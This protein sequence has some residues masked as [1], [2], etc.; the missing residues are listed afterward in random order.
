MQRAEKSAASANEAVGAQ[1]TLVGSL[2]DTVDTLS[3]SVASIA[4][5]L[6]AD[7]CD[8]PLCATR[9]DSA[10][11]LR[12]RISTTAQRLA[13]ALLAQEEALRI[14]MAARDVSGVELGRLRVEQTQIKSRRATLVGEQ[15]RRASLL[16]RLGLLPEE[17]TTLFQRRARLAQDAAAQI[18]RRRRK[19]RWEAH[20]VLGGEA[21]SAE[22][23]RAVRARDTAQRTLDAASRRFADISTMLDRAKT[24]AADAALQDATEINLDELAARLEQ[25]EAAARR[26]RE[27]VEAAAQSRTDADGAVTALEVEQAGLQ[28]R[29]AEIDPCRTLTSTASSGGLPPIGCHSQDLAEPSLEAIQVVE[30]RV[31]SPPG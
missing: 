7:A 11:A 30:G 25:A 5:H 6:P 16:G 17:S 9:F 4:A 27:A 28:A 22:Q 14:L 29:L 24:Q 23:S 31:T 2:H 10:A 20:P 18:A 21:F 19:E 3:N 15:E 12:E 1:E 8:C 13:P 26:A